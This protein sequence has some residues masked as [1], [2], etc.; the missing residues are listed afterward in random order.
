MAGLE[1]FIPRFIY[2][3]KLS[4][5]IGNWTGIHFGYVSELDPITNMSP[6]Y[7]GEFYMN[8]GLSGLLIGFFFLGLFSRVFDNSIKFSNVNW[9]N[10]IYI[11]NIFWLES[12]VGSTILPFIKTFI[13][14][15]IS[16]FII[17][18][19]FPNHK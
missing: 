19:L 2:P 11:A 12:F 13:F 3:D 14:F 18:K 4:L 5:N 15:A 17:N 9:F 10:A 6:S 8:F 16:V 1:S 7:L